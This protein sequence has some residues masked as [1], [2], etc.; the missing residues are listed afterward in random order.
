[1]NEEWRDVKGYEGLYQVSSDGR[2]RSQDKWKFNGFKSFLFKGRILR[3]RKRPNGYVDVSLHKDRSFKPV[4]VHRIVAM[5]FLDGVDG[6]PYV[7][8]KNAN[9][10]DNR[11][12]NLEWCTPKE[13]GAHAKAHGLYKPLTRQR[14]MRVSLWVKENMS[15]PVIQYDLEGNK[16]AEFPSANEA[17]RRLGIRQGLISTVCRG[18][19]PKTH[20][21]VFKYKV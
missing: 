13:N 16:L 21:Y 18:E 11:S 7:N 1:M 6:K 17:G 20:S 12:I 15:K 4:L 10:S 5:A 14:Q 9:K 2:V 3:M 19:K 8:H